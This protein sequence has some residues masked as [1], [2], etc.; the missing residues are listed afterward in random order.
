MTR[1][2]AIQIA[3]RAAFQAT[4]LKA[5]GRHDYLPTTQEKAETWQPH[6]WVVQAILLARG[7]PLERVQAFSC[8]QASQ[9]FKGVQQPRCARWCGHPDHCVAS[10]EPLVGDAEDAERYAYAKTLEG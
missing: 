3:R 6:E 9:S 1:E 7:A 8:A 10:F 2:Q 4:H 5:E